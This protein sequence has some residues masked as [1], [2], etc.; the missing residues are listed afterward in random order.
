MN[1]LLTSSALA[2][3][4]AVIPVAAYASEEDNQETSRRADTSFS[5]GE[6]VWGT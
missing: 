2:L 5:V 4:L 1:R 3:A 6:I